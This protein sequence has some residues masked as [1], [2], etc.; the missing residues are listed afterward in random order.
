LRCCVCVCVCA[1]APGLHCQS[2]HRAR[3][4]LRGP[5]AADPGWSG[6]GKVVLRTRTVRQRRYSAVLATFARRGQYL[7]WSRDDGAGRGSQYVPGTWSYK[8]R[9]VQNVQHVPSAGAT[10]TAVPITGRRHNRRTPFSVPSLPES[11]SSCV[12]CHLPLVD[13]SLLS[14]TCTVEN[15]PELPAPASQQGNSFG[16]DLPSPWLLRGACCVSTARTATVRDREGAN[17]R[18]K[19]AVLHPVKYE[20]AC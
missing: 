11:W 15:P 20:Q 13:H 10:K 6:L 12:R 3:L 4:A 1:C 5:A 8:A 14:R 2:F 16:S 18:T 9:G 17:R 7:T 19:A